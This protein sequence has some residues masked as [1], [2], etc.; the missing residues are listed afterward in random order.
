MATF[1]GQVFGSAKTSAS[2]GG[3]YASGLRTFAQSYEGSVIVELTLPEDSDGNRELMVEVQVNSNTASRGK[4]L[5]YGT[6]DEFCQKV[7]GVTL[8][9]DCVVCHSIRVSDH[10]GKKHLKYRYNIGSY[11][12]K[13]RSVHDMH[14]RC[15]FTV[16]EVDRLVNFVKYDRVHQ[17]DVLGGRKAYK[18]QVQRFRERGEAN[19]RGVLDEML[20][21]GKGWRTRG[22]C[23]CSTTW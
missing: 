6:L 7:G 3:T 19:D 16:D 4:S 5:F 18:E 11:V 13:F 23:G 14:R 8:K 12:R 10:R 20:G 1:Y 9:V 22:R 17:I 15:Y 2:G 21:G